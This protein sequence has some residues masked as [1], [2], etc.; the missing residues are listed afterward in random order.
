MKPSGMCWIVTETKNKNSYGTSKFR[1][2]PLLIDNDITHIISNVFLK[3]YSGKKGWCGVGDILK[4]KY[5]RVSTIVQ[6]YQVFVFVYRNRR[7]MVKF[8]YS[9]QE[10]LISMLHRT[11]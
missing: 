1:Y 5:M 10:T 11:V 7:K 6:K 4:S 2:Y 8:M 9:L 3:A